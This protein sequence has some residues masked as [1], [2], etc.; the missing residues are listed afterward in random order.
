MSFITV[1]PHSALGPFPLTPTRCTDVKDVLC[2]IVPL[3]KIKFP[4]PG[5][6]SPSSSF[7][8]LLPNFCLFLRAR[9]QSLTSLIPTDSVLWFYSDVVFM[10]LLILLSLSLPACHPRIVRPSLSFVCS[11]SSLLLFSSFLQLP[12]SLFWVSAMLMCLLPSS[13]CSLPSRG[14]VTSPSPGSCP[15][16]DP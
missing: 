3:Q 1:P 8:I 15:R 4:Q 14:P 11:F 10:S 6:N 13:S 7:L 5:I 12:S 9:V 16:L 2:V